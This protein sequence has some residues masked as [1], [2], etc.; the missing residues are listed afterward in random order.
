MGAGSGGPATILIPAG[1]PIYPRRWRAG[2]A[3]RCL[4]MLWIRR[5]DAVGCCRNRDIGTARGGG[6]LPS[7][8][9][10]LRP[11]A[12]TCQICNIDLKTMRNGGEKGLSSLRGTAAWLW[13]THG[14]R[15][16]RFV[17]AW[18]M[19]LGW[20]KRRPS[21]TT[22]AGI[23]T[24]FAKLTKTGP[25]GTGAKQRPACPWNEALEVRK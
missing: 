17:L 4:E 19:T 21:S 7:L 2:M 14:S 11:V 25:E 13:F 23:G 9:K 1:C 22:L 6:R 8:T 16:S 3:P 20:E 18:R 5:R 10:G 15:F 12:A 24:D